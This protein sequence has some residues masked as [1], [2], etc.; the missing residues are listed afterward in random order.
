VPIQGEERAAQNE[1]E[2]RSL[3]AL[4]RH[5]LDLAAHCAPGAPIPLELLRR[6]A[7]SKTE[8]EGGESDDEASIQNPKSGAL[9]RI[10]NP[11]D[12]AIHRLVTIGLASY[13]DEG[14]ALYVHRLVAAFARK[15]Q[16]HAAA[17]EAADKVADILKWITKEVADAGLPAKMQPLLPHAQHAVEAAETRGS[18]HAAT[19]LNNIGYHFGSVADYASARALYERALRIDEATFGPDH[20]NVAIRVNN[21]GMV[22]Q[23]QGDL[24]VARAYL[25]RALSIF[26]QKLGPEHPN[27][28]IVRGTSHASWHWGIERGTA[29]RRKPRIEAAPFRCLRSSAPSPFKHSNGE[30]RNGGSGG[31]RPSAPSAPPLPPRANAGTAEGM[32]RGGR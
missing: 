26:E 24:P 25:E 12:E 3:N 13:A 20:P 17:T 16:D 15:Q 29:E 19:L 32:R 10:Q 27:T 6:A 7:Q 21:L 5:L 28:R 14:G 8:D 31:L 22:A 1:E 18:E 9:G 23:D 11:T 4:A 30:Q 2:L